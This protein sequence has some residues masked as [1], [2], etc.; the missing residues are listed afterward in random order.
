MQRTIRLPVL[1]LRSGRQSANGDQQ[2]CD[3]LR[4]L[5]HNF[6]NRLSC[7]VHRP[8]RESTVEEHSAVNPLKPRVYS[9]RK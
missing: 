8:L 5:L 9:G 7:L 1:A 6:A 3:K 2:G 4:K